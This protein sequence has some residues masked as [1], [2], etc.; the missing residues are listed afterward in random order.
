MMAYPRTPQK[1][2]PHPAALREEVA[3][4]L[5]AGVHVV[6]ETGS[7]RLRILR[8]QRSGRAGIRAS[9]PH[10]PRQGGGGGYVQACARHPV[11][12]SRPA[13]CAR[14]KSSLHTERLRQ[15]A[16]SVPQTL[17]RPCGIEPVTVPGDS[18][19]A[20]EIFSGMVSALETGE[21]HRCRFHPV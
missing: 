15:I 9:V 19:A 14:A 10:L 7:A 5:F 2:A 8:A 21:I 1:R 3:V 17:L 13:P 11:A 16:K 18:W 6:N 4:A 20:S 12:V